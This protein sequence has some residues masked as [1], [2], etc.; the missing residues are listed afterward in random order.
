[1]GCLRE[2]I[3]RNT[4]KKAAN[5]ILNLIC[6]INDIIQLDDVE[7]LFHYSQNLIKQFTLQ[8]QDLQLNS[9]VILGLRYAL[10]TA[11]DEA[12]LTTAWGA[13]SAWA[14]QSL[15]QK[16]H[17][18]NWGG[19][20]FYVVLDY[21][22]QPPCQYPAIEIFYLLLCF[23]FKGKYYN[24]S[25]ITHDQLKQDILVNMQKNVARSN[26][27]IKQSLYSLI[28]NNL[29][30][31]LNSNTKLSFIILLCSFLFLLNVRSF[32]QSEPLINQLNHLKEEMHA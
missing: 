2:L 14:R 12:V 18:E 6:H 8:L 15:L 3:M 32:H 16:F 4:L 26:S 11:V 9:Q 30:Y 22:M 5:P 17:Q 21:F 29:I 20:R 23:G 13:S 27:E 19:E 24:D 28:K 1:M 25:Q 10:C 31:R 7:S